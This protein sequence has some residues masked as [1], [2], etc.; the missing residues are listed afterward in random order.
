MA[1]FTK[2]A[3]ETAEDF[4]FGKAPKPVTLKN[5]LVIGGGTVYPEVNFTLPPMSI[6]EGT[7]KEVYAN[8]REIAEGISKRAYE[9][10]APG[11]VAEIELLPPTTFH[12]EWGAEIC[13]I[14]V[15]VIKEY[16]TK[17][18]VKGAVRITPVDI[19]EGRDLKHMYHGEHWDNVLKTFQL[20]AEAGADLLSIESIGGKD[21]H[22][23]GLMDG[24][25]A[26]CLFA[27]GVI[28]AKD[29]EKLWG[30]IVKIANATGTIPAGDTACGFANTAM[31]LAETNMIPRVFSAA[32]RAMAGVRT[33]VAVEAGAKGP[34]KDCG[35]E[36]V[37]IK[38]VSGTPISMEGRTA[39]CAHLS[40]VGNV[41]GCA[42]DLW[43]NESIQNIKLL[44]G[45]APTVSI[46]QLIYDCRLFNGATKAGPDAARL[47]RDL[48]ADGDSYLD[49][50]AYTLR[51][52]IVLK[53]AKGVVKENGHYAQ[54]KK[55][56]ELALLEIK[57]GHAKGALNLSDKEIRQADKIM[58]ALD[59]LPADEGAFVDKIAGTCKKFNPK[60]YDM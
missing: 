40:S 36:G 28:G 23:E 8:Y 41:A 44:G 19:R 1:K 6:E 27:L 42:C 52:D 5:G 2:T 57:D 34:D 30:E 50:Q 7:L 4:I 32:V 3:Y 38:A 60:H 31:V 26:K 51:P 16:E 49:P 21:V 25:I 18:G 10:F 20:S 55:A 56:A 37:F 47:L 35:Y 15:D 14:V 54:A 39:A 24:D 9:L 12:P 33:L 59:K 46:E 13:K 43:S 11:F 29:M 22:D 45:M 53:I 58:K 17:H 48:H